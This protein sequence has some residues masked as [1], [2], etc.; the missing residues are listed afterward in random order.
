MNIIDVFA[1]YGDFGNFGEGVLIGIFD[2]REA[3][4]Q[5][6]KGRGSLD[7]G[8]DGKIKEKKAIQDG[9]KIYLLKYEE[10]VSI[11]EIVTPDPRMKEELFAVVIKEIKGRTQFM[12]ILRK[13]TSMSVGDVKIFMDELKDSPKDTPWDFAFSR[14]QAEA[15]KKEVETDNTAVVEFR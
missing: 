14:Q 12:K 6:A 2:N 7:C 11:N 13:H 4:E 15:F 1:V 9:E 3:A 5:A 8:G 10:P